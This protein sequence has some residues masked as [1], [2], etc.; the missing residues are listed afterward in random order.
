MTIDISPET[1]Q[2]V[3][4]LLSSGHFRSFDDLIVTSV[5]AWREQNLGR[6]HSSPRPGG[7]EKALEFVE[8]AKSHRPTPPLSD[9][10]ISRSSLNSDR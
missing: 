5:K 1:E 6:P 4:E 9:E 8:W 7:K 10:A 3:R 2:V